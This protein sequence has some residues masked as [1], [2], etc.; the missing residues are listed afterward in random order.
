MTLGLDPYPQALLVTAGCNRIVGSR[1]CSLEVSQLDPWK[2]TGS[3]KWKVSGVMLNSGGGSPWKMMGWKMILSS[4]GFFGGGFPIFRGRAVKLRRCTWGF[5]SKNV[6]RHPG[7]DEPASWVRRVLWIYASH[8][9]SFTGC[10]MSRT[11]NHP[12]MWSRSNMDLK[13]RLDHCLLA[14]WNIL[15]CGFE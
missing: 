12:G 5:P 13:Y 15:E 6:I 7:G 1:V 11:N 10:L 8:T 14:T 9:Y 4:S 3:P 2:V